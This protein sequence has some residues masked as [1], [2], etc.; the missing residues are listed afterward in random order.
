MPS[1]RL[2]LLAEH[3]FDI[4]RDVVVGLC[5]LAENQPFVGPLATVVKTGISLCDSFRSNEKIAAQFK[6]RLLDISCYVDVACQKKFSDLH[7]VKRTVNDLVLILEDANKYFEIFTKRGFI[8]AILCGNKPAA[9]LNEYDE[10]ITRKLNDL[11]VSLNLSQMNLSLQ[12]YDVV[13]NVEEWLHNR[14]GLEAVD[15]NKALMDELAQLVGKS[16]ITSISVID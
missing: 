8:V 10:A 16:G 15:G 1:P 11:V 7:L 6:D 5:D 12:M 9:K 4:A 14:G 13:C 2:Q 3:G